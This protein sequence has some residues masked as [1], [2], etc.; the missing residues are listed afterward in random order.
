MHVKT[1]TINGFLRVWLLSKLR[2][3]RP[4][5]H[6]F[7]EEQAAIETWLGHIARA[8]EIDLALAIEI[9]ACAELIKGYG[10]THERGMASYMRIVDE[11]VEPALS[12]ALA[13]G[14]AGDALANARAAALADPTGRRLAEVIEAIAEAGMKRAAE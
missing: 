3:W 9:A 13:A 4:R 14:R 11:V 8:A 7:R 10:D 6:R 12:G 2:P 1:T 5:T